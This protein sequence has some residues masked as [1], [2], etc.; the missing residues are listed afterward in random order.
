[1]FQQV[2]IEHYCT[3]DTALG[4]TDTEVAKQKEIKS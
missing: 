1:L 4:I 2:H 3:P